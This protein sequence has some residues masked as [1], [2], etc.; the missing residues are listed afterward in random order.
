MQGAAALVWIA[1]Q[2]HAQ[3]V[4][5]AALCYPRE[6]G[7]TFMGYWSAGGDEV[8]ITRLIA[9]GPRAFRARAAFEPDQQ[10]Q[11][12]EIARHY[13]ASG[14][15][16]VYLGDWHSHPGAASGELSGT[17]RNVLSRIIRTPKARATRPISLVFWGGPGSWHV[18][19]WVATLT[20]RILL[21]ARLS[22]VSAALQL[23]EAALQEMPGELAK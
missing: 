3:C 4:R 21:P 23:Y 17:D 9:A 11:L 10:W 19:A 1:Q 5:E 15:R 20:T 22:V 6:T 18:S 7:G 2:A 8:V 16:E 12:A 13:C 14:R